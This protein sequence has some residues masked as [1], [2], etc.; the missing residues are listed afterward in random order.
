M[1]LSQGEKKNKEAIKWVILLKSLHHGSNDFINM[2]VCN[3]NYKANNFNIEINF[4]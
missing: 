3:N 2:H 1:H 4:I